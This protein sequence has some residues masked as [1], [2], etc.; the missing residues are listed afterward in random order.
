M[1]SSIR[2]SNL[3]KEKMAVLEA[4]SN[5]GNSDKKPEI[6]ENESSNETASPEVYVRKNKDKDKELDLLW[7]DFRLPKGERS[8]IV[9]LGMGFVAGVIS[10]LLVSACIGLSSGE[11]GFNFD[12]GSKAPASVA[13]APSDEE[14][15]T[16]SE[17]IST[18]S[19]ENTNS[20]EEIAEKKSKF[21]FFGGSKKSAEETSA[22][23]S[24]QDKE[25]TVQSGDTMES[26]LK[27]FYGQYTPEKAEAVMKINNM[28]NP[29]KLAIDQKLI[30]PD[31][32]ISSETS[33]AE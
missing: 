19:E 24:V 30:I 8:P 27:K 2:R 16:T 7:K 26:I 21:G 13:I 6:I 5:Y 22:T 3:S 32:P 31:V 4:L 15:V 9:F 20:D 17:N 25:Y 10:T 29:D 1:D 12:F 11:F 18:V 33:T 23:P 14:T 28:T